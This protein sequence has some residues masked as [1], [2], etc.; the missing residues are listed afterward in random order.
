MRQWV[1]LLY[2]GFQ[3]DAGDVKRKGG[4]SERMWEG[5]PGIPGD[6]RDP[7]HDIICLPV[8]LRS[9]Q[10]T[11]QLAVAPAT[12]QGAARLL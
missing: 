11:G 2:S 1:V 4:H 6:G 3:V 8:P 12:V 9:V 10:R 5:G 7:S